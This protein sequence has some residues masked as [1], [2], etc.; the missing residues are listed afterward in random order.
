MLNPK[1]PD[2]FRVVFDCAAKYNGLSL[3]DMLYSGPDITSNDAFQERKI[4]I[5]ADIEEM[6]MQV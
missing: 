5:A 6:L 3:N 2:K 4:A 1:K